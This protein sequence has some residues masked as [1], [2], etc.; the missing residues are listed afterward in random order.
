[1]TREERLEEWIE[2]VAESEPELVTYDGLD[3]AIIGLAR[4][5][6]ST[7]AIAYDLGKVIEILMAD[8]MKREDAVEHFHFN[9]VGAWVGI[10]TP[11]CL[12]RWDSGDEPDTKEVP[13][14]EEEDA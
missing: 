12:E 11:I 14:K 8:G 6:T 9:V 3:D 13:D 1:M 10:H 7:T 4:Q 5:F 2:V